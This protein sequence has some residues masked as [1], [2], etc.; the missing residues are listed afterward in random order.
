MAARNILIGLGN[1]SMSDDGAGLVVA[2]AAHR[3]LVGFDLELS[4][5]GGFEVVDRLLAYRTAAIVDSMVTGE[6]PPGTAVRLELPGARTLRTVGS[7]GIGLAEAIGLARGWGAPVAGRI[8]L[9]GIEV[10]EPFKVGDQISPRVLDR[11]EAA[12]AEIAD[13][14]KGES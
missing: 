9:F 6:H 14:I 3:H 12:A 10:I 8:L 11:V 5:A 2:R 1:P 7:H 13:V 4:S